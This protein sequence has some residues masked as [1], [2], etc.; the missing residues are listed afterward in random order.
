MT[1]GLAW[2]TYRRVGYTS[3]YLLAVYVGQ[4]VFSYVDSTGGKALRNLR[5]MVVTLFTA[6]VLLVLATYMSVRL[7]SRPSRRMV[8]FAC[9]R[10]LMA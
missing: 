6:A 3:L 4:T 2:L 1:T 5:W 10:I 8:S 9:M 7:V